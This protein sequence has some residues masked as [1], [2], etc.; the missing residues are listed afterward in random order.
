MA[1]EWW[2]VSAVA[3]GILVFFYALIAIEMISAIIKGRQLLTNPLL[4]A[5]AAVFVTC[6]FGHGLHLSHA[7]STLLVGSVAAMEATK[8]EFADPRLWVW[9]GF[10]ALVTIYF[11]TLRSRFAIVYRGAALNE[12]M[13]KREQQ[14]MDLHDNV[15]QGLV[16]AKMELDLGD[17]KGGIASIDATLA[18]ARGIITQLLGKEGSE[19][20]LGPGDLRRKAPAGAPK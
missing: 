4:T 16:Q 5:T 14:A 10:T 17:R 7:T 19:V 13:A 20:A 9:D 15:V 8:A 12:D 3:N 6:T 1:I 11:Y 18:S 2:L